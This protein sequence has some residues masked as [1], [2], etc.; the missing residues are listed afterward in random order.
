MP[1]STVFGR[2]LT[3]PPFG[4]RLVRWRETETVTLNVRGL[5]FFDRFYFR[6]FVPM[7]VSASQQDQSEWQIEWQMAL[8]RA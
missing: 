2:T 1:V 5:R 7:A 6:R 8:V 3:E 4:V